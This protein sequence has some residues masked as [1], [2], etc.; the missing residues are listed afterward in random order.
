MLQTALIAVLVILTLFQNRRLKTMSEALDKLT[1]EVAQ[2]DTVIDSAISTIK[3]LAQQIR[4]SL[5][6]PA[7]LQRLADDL[8]AKSVAL[9]AA[10][11]ESTSVVAEPV[12]FTP[13]PE[14]DP[15]TEPAPADTTAET[16]GDDS[17]TGTGSD[18][19]DAGL[20]GDGTTIGGAAGSDV[21]DDG[22]TGKGKGK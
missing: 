7:A 3:G 13:A 8:D 5:T 15:A 20:A 6:D 19:S 4:D 22:K 14:P 1:A 11:A 16:T 2:I 17:A 10:I 9:S 12:P 18:G 21:V